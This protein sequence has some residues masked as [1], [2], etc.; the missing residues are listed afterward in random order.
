MPVASILKV[1]DRSGNKLYEWSDNVSSVLDK[2]AVQHLNSV[3]TDQGARAGFNALNISGE[4][5]AGKTGTTNDFRDAWTLMYTPS[6]ATGVWVGNND[7]TVMD[8]MADGVIIAAP[9]ANYYMTRLLEGLPDE[10]F[11]APPKA[12]ANKPVLWGEIGEKEEKYVDKNTQ[13][14]IPDDCLAAYPEEYKIKKEFKEVH[15]ILHYLK[16]EDPLGS[17]PAD[18]ATDPMYSSW[19][20]A[21]QRWAEGQ[22]DYLTAET[23]FED[24]NLRSPDQTPTVTIASPLSNAALTEKTFSI[25]ARIDP[26]TN[27]TIKKVEYIIDQTVVDVVTSDPFTTDYQPTTLTTGAHTLTVRATNDRDN[28]TEVTVAFSYSPAAK[29]EEENK[30]EDESD[31]NSNKNTNKNTNSNTNKKKKN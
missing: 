11:A 13:H 4:T 6:F 20:A 10:T 28:T 24:C 1:E 30:D 29:E 9:I 17:P 18:P 8:Y 16:K 15:T 23:E 2:A 12:V 3:L 25:V 27:R 7:N 31:S 26:G 19:E 5:I 21:V 14:I 22:P